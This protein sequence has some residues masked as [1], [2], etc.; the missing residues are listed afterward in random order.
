MV[1]LQRPDRVLYNNKNPPAHHRVIRAYTRDTTHE[2]VICSGNSP[3]RCLSKHGFALRKK[4]RLRALFPVDPKC[5]LEH[6]ATPETKE[7]SPV[8]PPHSLHVS[9]S[10]G[11]APHSLL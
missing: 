8:L 2:S 11:F 4:H 7:V 6:P 5:V 10:R 1:Y 9:G 3:V